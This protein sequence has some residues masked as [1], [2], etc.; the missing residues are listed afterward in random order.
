MKCLQTLGLKRAAFLS[1]QKHISVHRKCR[2]FI[3]ATTNCIIKIVIDVRT[4]NFPFLGH[5]F[6]FQ[7]INHSLATTKFDACSVSI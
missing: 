7:I 5:F 6:S 3:G 2:R 1:K 4:H